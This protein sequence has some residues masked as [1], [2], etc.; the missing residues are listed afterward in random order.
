M[1]KKWASKKIILTTDHFF[2]VIYTVY[3][4]LHKVETKYKSNNDPTVLFTVVND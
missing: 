3:S 1:E 4:A 2:N